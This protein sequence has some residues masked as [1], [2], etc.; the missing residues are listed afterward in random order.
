MKRVCNGFWT[1]WSVVSRIPVPVSFSPRY[2]ETGLFLP[3]VGIIAALVSFGVMALMSPVTDDT[4]LA[5]LVTLGVSY[6]LFNLFH[7]DGLLD[8]ADAFLLWAESERRLAILKDSRIGVFAFF[9]GF[10]YLA[11]KIRL[12]VLIVSPFY[13]ILSFSRFSADTFTLLGVLFFYPVT[14]R[15][16]AAL[17][18]CFSRPARKEGLG[19]A[20]SS[21]SVSAAAAGIVGAFV[22]SAV[23]T[24]IYQYSRAGGLPV[25]PGML[26]VNL[27][28]LLFGVLIGGVGVGGLYKKR[29]GGFTGDALGA[30]VELGELAHLAWMFI[31]LSVLEVIG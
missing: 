14:G 8:T 4:L 25:F 7:F 16:A 3:M 9:A 13:P 24:V 15:A 29:V 21:Y 26:L 1:T 19:S 17:I 11:L 18:P 10:L 6:F 27:G 30:A 20:L 5:V 2:R 22:L 12:L 28:A 31:G 23:F